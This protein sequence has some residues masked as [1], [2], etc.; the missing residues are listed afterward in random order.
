MIKTAITILS[1]CGITC[2]IAEE[3]EDTIPVMPEIM[4]AAVS[5]T[6]DEP[7]VSAAKA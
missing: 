2:P 3:T 7:P 1:A 5:S 6:G 4:E